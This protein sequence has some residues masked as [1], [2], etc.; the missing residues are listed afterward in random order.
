MSSVR[1]ENVYKYYD[2][3]PNPAVSDF[4]FEIKDKEFVVFVGPSLG[5]K[6]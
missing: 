6:W 4:T 3:N 2:K 5:T 1:L